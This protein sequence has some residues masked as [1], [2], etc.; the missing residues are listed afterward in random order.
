M[1]CQSKTEVYS[2]VCGYYRP[3][4]QWNEGKVDEYHQRVK[5]NLTLAERSAQ[6]RVDLQKTATCDEIA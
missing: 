4:S 5:F 1:K 3:I 2:R 6:K